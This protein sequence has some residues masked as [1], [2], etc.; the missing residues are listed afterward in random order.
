MAIHY[1]IFY[2]CSYCT[3]EVMITKSLLC[4][5]LAISRAAGMAAP[6][7]ISEEG[8]CEGRQLIDP[9]RRQQA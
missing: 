1:T 9:A 4:G 8:D 5:L 2:M 3:C 7:V 6:S